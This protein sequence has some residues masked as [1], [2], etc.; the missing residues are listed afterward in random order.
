MARSRSATP[1]SVSALQQ[2][3]QRLLAENA[4]LTKQIA[5]S[6]SM[7]PKRQTNA[8]RSAL[9]YLCIILAG[10]TL[11]AS[12]FLFWVGR[13]LLNDKQYNSIMSS[14]IQKPSVQQAAA[15]YAT[16][17]IF[18]NFDTKQYIEEALPPRAAFLA[19]T[20]NSQLKTATQATIQKLIA[21]DKFQQAWISA[22]AKAH[23]RIINNLKNYSG[24]GTISLNDVFQQLTGNLKDTRLAFLANKQLP[25]KVGS[26]TVVQ[27]DWL[28]TAH[29]IVSVA[30]YMKW[31]C[32]GLFLI[33]CGAAVWLSKRRRR[34]VLTLAILFA[35]L[36]LL[37]AIAARVTPN[38]VAQS[39][40][41]AYQAAAKDVASIVVQ[42][43]I[44]QT[45]T[46]LSLSLLAIVVAWISG[47]YPAAVATRRRVSYLTEG[48]VHSAIF[49]HQENSFTLW[50]GRH[51]RPLQWLIVVIVSFAM[52]V[53]TLSPINVLVYGLVMAVLVLI[54]E[55]LSAPTT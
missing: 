30:P 27:A 55:V 42:P 5:D 1:K 46:I 25:Q 29:R 7:P 54:V 13:S 6:K 41:S 49:G 26:I 4:S 8:W 44:V 38:I 36:M 10:A 20:L 19:P 22:N 40:A 34:M 2:E 53:A 47:Q 14:V 16:D 21:S 24:D 45:R 39:V 48:K 31:L 9:M 17:Q 12:N 35:V 52:L 32:A 28:P 50:V 37:S 11:V 18:L 33:F 15:L 51:R 3:N 43:L 23:S